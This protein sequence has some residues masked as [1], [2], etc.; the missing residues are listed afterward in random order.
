MEHLMPKMKEVADRI[1]ASE[2]QRRRLAEFLLSSGKGLSFPVARTEP[3]GI[4]IAA[5]D[6]GIVKRSLHG[7]DF[8]LNRAVGVMFT[9]SKGRVVGSH[10]FPEKSPTPELSVAEALSDTDYSHSAS[11][12][13]QKAEILTAIG[14][15][16]SLKPNIM[17][18]DGSIIPHYQDKPSKSSESYSGYDEIGRAHV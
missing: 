9:Y 14:T 2:S 11:I 10:Y 7:F 6:G 12:I 3:D 1:T 15:V 4:K 5:V 17:L 8:I 13:R 16:K 18:L